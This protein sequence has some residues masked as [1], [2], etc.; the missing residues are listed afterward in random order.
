[1]LLLYL[2]LAQA[3][4]KLIYTIPNIQSKCLAVDAVNQELHVRQ[5]CKHSQTLHC[6][7]SFQAYHVDICVTFTIM[8]HT[9]NTHVQY[10]SV[11]YTPSA[12]YQLIN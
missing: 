2:G 12:N 8:S 6:I 10:G 9:N 4:L 5:Y 1:M 3:R 11:Q 7:C